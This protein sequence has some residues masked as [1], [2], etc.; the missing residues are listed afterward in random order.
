VIV[1]IVAAILTPVILFSLPWLLDMFAPTPTPQTATVPAG[2]FVATPDQWS[3]LR[4]AT[5]ELGSFQDETR[6]DGQVST[7]DD[8]TTAIFSPFSG[9][10]TRVLVKAGDRV[11][12]G[13]TLFAVRGAEFIQG[14]SDLATALGAKATA[15][16]Q[17][18]VSQNA[19]ARLHELLK[20]NGA[21][22]KDVEQSDADLEAA[23]G[24]LRTSE[25]N[26]AGARNRLRMLGQTDAQID[27]LTHTP[28]GK[29][30]A[31]TTVTSPISGTV[32]SRSLA[33]GQ[34][35]ANVSSG[36][37]TPAFVVSDT[38]SIWLV[39]WMRAV[40]AGKVK[41]GEPVDVTVSE[42][43][44]RTFHGK[45]DFVAPAIDPVTHRLNVR[46][47]VSNA[48]GALKPQMF[49]EFTLFGGAP[50][51]AVSVPEASVIYEGDTARV[52]VA[53]PGRTL[54]LRQIQAGGARDGK[55]EVLSGLRAGETV[56]TSGALFIDRAATSD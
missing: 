13:Q 45:L 44:G 16:A 19:N 50:S 36:G 2:V 48:D 52:W 15:E 46:A 11:R 7:D 38:A 54:A 40:D 9:T 55:V 26:L 51:A 42:L 6:T 41:L 5:A 32:M 56:V 30:G 8:H 34:T 47:T 37:N 17:L 27:V 12:A 4:F 18:K 10:V 20:A 39:G 14:E 21:A 29:A 43:P 33:V 28:A 23:K 1:L 24:A 25:A 22:Q 35:I 31:E 49:A 53:G 3:T